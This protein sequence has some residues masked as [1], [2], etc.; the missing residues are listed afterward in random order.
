MPQEIT[1]RQTCRPPKGPNPPPLATFIVNAVDECSIP[2]KIGEELN[3][4]HAAKVK[5]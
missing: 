5:P 2:Y 3:A 4:N 1:E